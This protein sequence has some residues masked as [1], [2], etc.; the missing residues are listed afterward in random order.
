MSCEVGL[1]LIKKRRMRQRH[2]TVTY[3]KVICESFNMTCSLWGFTIPWRGM[4][5]EF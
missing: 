4:G 3:E 1:R 2:A 5:R